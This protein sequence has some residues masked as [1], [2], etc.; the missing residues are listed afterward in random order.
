[1]VSSRDVFSEVMVS[2]VEVETSIRPGTGRIAWWVG[3]EGLKARADLFPEEESSPETNALRSVLTAAPRSALETVEGFEN[4]P[5]PPEMAPNVIDLPTLGRSLEEGSGSGEEGFA[6]DRMHD[7]TT[8][9]HG[10]IADVRD[11]G[12]KKDLNL[13]FE[14]PRAPRGYGA[15]D[16][17]YLYDN[18][19]PGL[20]ALR[21]KVRT[22]R[23]RGNKTEPR[24]EDVRGFYREYK[25][26]SVNRSGESD[27]AP[28][29]GYSSNT[30]RLPVVAKLQI[31]FS[32][33]ARDIHGPWKRKYNRNP[34]DPHDYLIHCVIEPVVTLWNPFDS[35]L[36]FREFRVNVMQ[37]PVTLRW[38]TNGDEVGPGWRHYSEIWQ[39]S[40][41]T[42]KGFDVRIKPTGG[43]SLITL[44]PGE[45]VTYSDGEAS[46]AEFIK[47]HGRHDD[48]HGRLS[49]RLD[50]EPGWHV[51]G[52]YY[53]D[54][55]AQ[56]RDCI[57]GNTDDL[58]GVTVK[59][60]RSRHA[61]GMGDLYVNLYCTKPNG[62][63]GF[64]GGHRIQFRDNET[65]WLP[66]LE[67]GFDTPERTFGEVHNLKQPFMLLNVALKTEGDSRYPSLSWVHNSPINQLFHAYD[68]D[69]EHMVSMQYEMEMLPMGSFDDIPTIEVAPNNRNG[70]FGPGLY[71]D[72]GLNFVTHAELP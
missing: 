30:Q 40:R 31:L 61:G 22:R 1:M 68:L 70:Y 27:F 16:N 8:S 69:E 65:N 17:S 10:V 28:T 52:G 33:W 44:A 50:Y 9:S 29:G 55:L 23:S 66:Q 35:P 18:S 37:I 53:T 25:D 59:G 24:W 67:A 48:W 12:L 15:D 20:S 41:N 5:P 32:Y 26:A 47:V 62:S 72:K 21:D 7:F 38:F 36:S 56:G 6:E 43:D 54:W 58:I 64:I 11:G 46:Q 13:L 39:V 45:V 42:R 51:L 63:G 34:D 3:D 57:P 49:A 2:E 19:S 71:A 4:Y 60:E 14:L